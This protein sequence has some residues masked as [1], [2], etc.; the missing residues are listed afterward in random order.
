MVKLFCAIVGTEGS[1]FLVRV[2]EDDSVDD[3]KD[4]IKAE[5]AATI[6]GDAKDL[7]LFLAKKDG[8]WLP[9]NEGLDTLLQS[10]IDTSSYLNMRASWKLSKPTLFGGVS[11]GEDVVHVLVVVPGQRLP[12]AAAANHEPHPTR[13]KGWEELNEVLD[14]NKRAKV[15]A[16]GES[17]TGYSYVSFSD[18]DRVM[19]TCRY[20][21]SSKVVENEKIDVPY[22]YLLLLTKAFGEIV[23][24]KEAKRLHFIVPVLACVCGLFEGEVRILAEETVTGKRV[25]GDGSFEF[26]IERGSK[27]VCIVE[28]KRDDFQQGLA[29]AYVGCEVLA[30]IEG[31]T[32][33]YSIVT[34][35]KEWYFSRSLDDKVE[36]DDATID[37]EHD[38]P[39]RESVKRIAEKIY[40]MLSEDD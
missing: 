32:K 26:V 10:E 34:K 18:V 11:L 14:R 13:K 3:L 37:L 19:R 21:Q 15:N 6:T 22:A 5:N 12:I 4:A 24:G 31:L 29:Q 36:R 25:H 2:D 33:L 38:V 9:D 16:A 30:D 23:T 35:F 1:V 40:F 17:S 28:A 39:T 7:Q 27:R 8:A 20:E